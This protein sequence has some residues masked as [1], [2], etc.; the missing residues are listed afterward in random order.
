MTDDHEQD[1]ALDPRE[2]ERIRALLAGLGTAPDAS[3]M[4]PEVAARLD[5]TLAG[6]VAERS[7]GC[8]CRAGEAGTV[9]PL[10]RRWAPRAAAAAA[11]VIVVGAGGVAAANLGLF[12]GGARERQR[13]PGARAARPSRSRTP[14]HLRRHRTPSPVR[15]PRSARPASTPTWRGC[16]ATRPGHPRLADQGEQGGGGCHGRLAANCRLC[17]TAGDRRRA[18]HGRAVRREAR[19]PRRASPAERRAARRG[20]DLHRRPRARQRAGAGRGARHRP[21]QPGELRIGQPEPLAVRLG[22]CPPP[23]TVR[24]RRA[25]RLPT[26][27]P[28]PSRARWSSTCARRPSWSGRSRS[29][30]VRRS[31]RKS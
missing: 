24:R 23:K 15:C 10:R 30:T 8:G 13:S 12:N 4:P 16:C 3:T 19:G 20:V 25:N 1:P 21:E 28:G 9:V 6:L 5:E 31:P 27:V 7:G 11:A 18:D 22:T 14:P 29:R 26:A 17:R 2:D